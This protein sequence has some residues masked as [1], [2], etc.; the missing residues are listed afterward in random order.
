[1]GSDIEVIENRRQDTI[2][3]STS[4]MKVNTQGC[5]IKG[6]PS[7]SFERLVSGLAD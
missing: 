7:I 3:G 6:V 1:M 5:L 2:G 4:K